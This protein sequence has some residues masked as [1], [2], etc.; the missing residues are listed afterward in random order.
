MPFGTYQQRQCGKQHKRNEKPDDTGFGFVPD[1]QIL[2]RTDKV[3]CHDEVDERQHLFSD[4]FLDNQY[5]RDDRD[6]C[7]HH[8]NG[9]RTF[10]IKRS[11]HQDRKQHRCR[12]RVANEDDRTLDF[13]VTFD[14]QAAAP[15]PVVEI[16]HQHRDKRR[17]EQMNV[18]TFDII[19]I[20]QI[21]SSGDRSNRLPKCEHVSF[22]IETVLFDRVDQ[23]ISVPHEKAR[24]KPVFGFGHRFDHLMH[25]RIFRNKP[26]P[27]RQHPVVRMFDFVPQR[28]DSDER[29][30]DAPDDR[31]GRIFFLSET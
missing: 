6:K 22:P 14:E 5:Q 9:C 26:V 10:G 17:Q 1:D 20:K 7:I 8:R 21:G 23:R 12:K 28:R 3:Q 2:N 13:F 18:N 25:F 24:R 4:D 29:R 27:G 30:F 15:V 31:F 11:D 16:E 19:G